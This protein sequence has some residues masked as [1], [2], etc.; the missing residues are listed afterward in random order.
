MGKGKIV[1]GLVISD[2]MDK[3]CVV[4]VKRKI[5]H[6]LYKKSTI[7]QKKYHVH[8]KDNNAKI[9]DRV[10]IIESRPYSKE[11]N[12]KLLEIIK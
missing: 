10:K 8:D 6:Q 12:F 2:K 7:K 5:S 4:L 9:G 1:E 11:K 3:T